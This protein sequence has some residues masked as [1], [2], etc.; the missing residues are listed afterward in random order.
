M[1][2]ASQDRVVFGLSGEIERF[3]EGSVTVPFCG[4]YLGS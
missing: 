4:L 1:L 2:R 3:V